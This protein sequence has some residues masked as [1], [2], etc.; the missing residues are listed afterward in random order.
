VPP[1]AF[2]SSWP[3]AWQTGSLLTPPPLA[4]R[5]RHRLRVPVSVVVEELVLP[6]LVLPVPAAPAS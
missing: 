4:A 2:T 5:L 1:L 6:E 3:M